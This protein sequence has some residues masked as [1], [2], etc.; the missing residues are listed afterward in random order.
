MSTKGRARRAQGAKGFTAVPGKVV[1]QL[2]P[3]TIPSHTKGEKIIST[4]SARR[5]DV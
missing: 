4:D 5:G 3:D 1:E 2:I